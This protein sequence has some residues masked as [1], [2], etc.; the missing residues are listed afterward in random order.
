MKN[1]T[2][3]CSYSIFCY[4]QVQVPDDFKFESDDPS[5]RIDELKM[6]LDV[7]FDELIPEPEVKDH[8][9]IND[10]SFDMWYDVSID[11]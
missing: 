8:E 11:D 9:S 7:N 1:V 3:E 5:E 6:I 4:A 2:V 10:M